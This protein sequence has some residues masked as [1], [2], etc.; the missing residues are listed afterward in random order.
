[1]EDDELEESPYIELTK[2]LTFVPATEVDIQ[3]C[4]YCQEDFAN[5]DFLAI[6][7]YNCT[8]RFPR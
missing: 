7:K 2:H 3:T 1:M 5:L 8:A 4:P 6:H